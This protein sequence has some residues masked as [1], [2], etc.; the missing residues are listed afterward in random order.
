[1]KKPQGTKRTILS[2]REKLQMLAHITRTPI[3]YF[4]AYPLTA[5]NFHEALIYLRIGIVLSKVRIEIR[6]FLIPN[7]GSF[8]LD[9]NIIPNILK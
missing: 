3:C 7:F 5:I 4:H 6:F 9:S 1:M 2:E 8:Y